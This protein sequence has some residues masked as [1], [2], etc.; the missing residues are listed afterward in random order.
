MNVF[1]MPIFLGV[2]LS[3]AKKIFGAEKHGFHTGKACPVEMAG[4]NIVG[5]DFLGMVKTLYKTYKPFIIRGIIGRFSLSVKEIERLLL[6]PSGKKMQ[7]PFCT[8]DHAHM[9]C[10]FK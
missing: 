10:L 4:D 8:Y 2:H 3:Q 6:S 7:C 9:A 1:F 5:V